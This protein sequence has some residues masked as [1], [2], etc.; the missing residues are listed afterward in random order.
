MYRLLE[1]NPQLTA[2]A[3][4]IDLRMFLYRATKSRLL[5]KDQTLNDF[6]NAH[7]YYGFHRTKTGWV[8]REWAPSAYQLYLT[9]DFNKWDQTSHPL[10]KLD[11]GNWE[12]ELEGEEALWEGCKVKT[13]VDANMTR[14][15]HIPLYARRVVQDPKTITFTAEIVD[16]SKKF[17]W[18]DA[19]FQGDD[20][21]YIYEA[22]VGMAQEEGK[23]G[24]Y[25]EFADYTL[26]HVKKAGYNTI[27]LMAI[28]E[29]PYYGSFGYQVSNFFAASSWFGKPEDLKYLVNKAHSMGIRVLLDVVHSHAVKNTAEGINM[30]DG[31]VWQFF[32]DGDKG[33]HPAWGTKCF[34]Y[35]KTGVLHFLLSNLKFWMTEYHFDG[36]RF[37]GVTSM[38]Y[39][40]HGLGTDFNDNNKYFSYNTH[41]EAITYLQLANEL[42]RQVNPK[43]I[44]IAEDMSGMPGMALPIE[45]GGIGFDYRLGMGLPDMWI[46][47]VKGEDQ[48]WDINKMW[49]DMCLRRPGENTVAYVESHDQALVGDQTMIFRLA[50]ANMY[51]DMEKSCHNPVIDRAI[52][53]HKMIRLFTLAGGGEGYLNF[54]GNEFGHPEWIDFPREGNGWSFHY[55]RRQWSLKENGF[56]KYQWL[57]DFDEDMVKLTQENNMFDQRMADMLLMK[58]PEQTCAFYRNG[59]MFVFNFHFC[60]SLNNVLIPV[61]N[62]GEYTVVM[63][64]DDEKYGGFD[65]VKK[66]TYATKLFEGKHYIELYIPA[67]TCFVLKEKVILPPEEKTTKTV[68]K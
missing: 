7:N 30:F 62:P 13:V 25:R 12:L 14:T 37:D 41:T 56:L 43:A 9:G 32:H 4:D 65:N 34:D 35:G 33:E 31:T 8:Y 3:G 11:N 36:F 49:G 2:F 66:Q 24:T 27:Q 50:G 51:T 17:D 22:H 64:S 16:P 47:A 48:F 60:N 57:N 40:D 53:L 19:D 6:A 18:T 58:G 39:H 15:E 52:A 42:I 45:D 61:H 55:C 1:L 67:R 63:S 68:K 29:H 5:D 10:K 44:T 54:M 38:L 26:P 21:L 46:K 23:V 28:M 59:L 20:K